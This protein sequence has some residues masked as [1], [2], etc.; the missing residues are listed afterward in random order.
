MTLY[1]RNEN[2]VVRAEVSVVVE[3]AVWCGTEA[4]LEVL[5]CQQRRGTS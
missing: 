4:V 2:V 1:C 5:S 3:T